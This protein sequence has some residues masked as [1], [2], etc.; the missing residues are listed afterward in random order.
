MS[1]GSYFYHRDQSGIITRNRRNEMADRKVIEITFERGGKFLANILMSEAPKTCRAI[2]E[3][4]P[5]EETVAHATTA[6]QELFFK[7]GLGPAFPVEN[8][9]RPNAGD[10][11]YA[12][13]QEWQNILVY[14]GDFIC[15]PKYFNIFARISENLDELM[16][17]GKRVWSKGF[18]K[19]Y[20]SCGISS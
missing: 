9:V 15:F 13:D 18:E 5:I 17:V 6:G 7:G 20:L 3:K 19:V 4:L 2:L 11:G 1:C 8:A 12:A 16:E 10:I 14:Y